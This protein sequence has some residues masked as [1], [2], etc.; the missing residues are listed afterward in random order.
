MLLQL[1][2]TAASFPFSHAYFARHSEYTLLRVFCASIAFSTP[3]LAA[4]VAI[5]GGQKTTSQYS[6][7]IHFRSPVLERWECAAASRGLDAG[8]I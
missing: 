2:V 3:L 8:A 1:L 5:C 7:G 4:E 6:D